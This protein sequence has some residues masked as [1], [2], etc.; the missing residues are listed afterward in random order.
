MIEEV[1]VQRTVSTYIPDY[2]VSDSRRQYSPFTCFRWRTNLYLRLIYLIL[3]CAALS[4]FQTAANFLNFLN[5][6]P[7][8]GFS[9]AQNLL[10]RE[11]K[12]FGVLIQND[13]LKVKFTL[14]QAVKALRG[15]K[16]IDLLFL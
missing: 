16:R 12:L 1:S 3:N 5:W 10:S 2:M 8:V 4:H 9:F 15:S 13:P 11:P 7:S 14:E 6:D